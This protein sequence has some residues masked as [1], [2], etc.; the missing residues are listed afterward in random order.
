MLQIIEA[1]FICRD[2]L[3]KYQLCWINKSEDQGQKWAP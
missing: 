1:G 3:N 2:W